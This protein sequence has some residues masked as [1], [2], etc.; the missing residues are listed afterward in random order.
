MIF[1]HW[2]F[3]C[4]KVWRNLRIGFA[5]AA[6]SLCWSPRCWWGNPIAGGSSQLAVSHGSVGMKG[7][8]GKM[9]ECKLVARALGLKNIG[10]VWRRIFLSTP[11]ASLI[12]PPR[13]TKW[14]FPLPATGIPCW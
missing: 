5:L 14:Q 9:R 1:H 7:K 6:E 4:N 11:L 2:D 8:T 13:S 10:R 3:S 12:P